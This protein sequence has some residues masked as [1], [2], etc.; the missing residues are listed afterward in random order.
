MH[1]FLTII[2]FGNEKYIVILDVYIMYSWAVYVFMYLGLI[3]YSSEYHNE[4]MSY[5]DWHMALCT[6]S[7]KRICLKIILSVE[8]N[9]KHCCKS[10]KLS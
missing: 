9:A 2:Q 3:W 8:N 6:I 10:P 4:N 5:T 7:A 1:A